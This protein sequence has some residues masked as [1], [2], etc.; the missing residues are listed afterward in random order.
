MEEL[1]VVRF[2]G[3]LHDQLK[4]SADADKAL[5][6]A[7]RSAVVFLQAGAGCVVR[8]TPAADTVRIC[9]S[10]PENTPWDI[11]DLLPCVEALPQRRPSSSELRLV[12]LR[13]RGN[14]WATIVFSSLSA[15]NYRSS[16]SVVDRIVDTIASALDALDDARVARLRRRIILKTIG[17][18]R[19]KD[20]FY[21][22]LDTIRSLTHYDHSSALCL[23]ETDGT[24]ILVAEQIA[25]A[26]I[27]SDR[28]GLRI[29]IPSGVR[30]AVESET[31][32]GIV[33]SR[34]EWR[35]RYNSPAPALGS[36]LEFRTSD[37]PQGDLPPEQSILCVAITSRRSL[38]G[39]IKIA[40]QELDSLGPYEASL[41]A[42][43]LPDVALAV[44]YGEATDALKARL[45]AAERKHAMAE[46]ARG[47][48][49]D[50]NNALG[51]MKPL[52]EQIQHDLQTGVLDTSVLE[53]DLVAISRA[54][55]VCQR[56]F[57]GMLSFAR[58][59]SLARR[60]GAL[61]EAIEAA[62]AI[63]G[64]AL[65]RQA[66][67]VRAD[68]Q[69]GLPAVS[70]P[71]GELE[72]LCLNLFTNA[73]DA[74]PNGGVLTVCAKA[75]GEHVEFTVSDTGEGIDEETRKR[76]GEPFF[77]TKPQGTG[78]GLSICRAIIWDAG[79]RLEISGALG[80]GTSVLVKLPVHVRSSETNHGQ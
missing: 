51:T 58:R 36:L 9:Y 34:D 4:R 70:A 33:R 37:S 47:V 77:T 65:A 41:L 54:L 40:G 44:D 28:I 79:G 6:F 17:G 27:P 30:L 75:V 53:A 42:E 56:L 43:L 1:E 68:V 3:A 73:R 72:Q 2:L 74:M 23:I 80:K 61:D 19:P 48:A 24:A 78:L 31:I 64:D 29:P 21:H 52:V 16:V 15:S 55:S 38:L 66:V 11:A 22:I 59:Q 14:P 46:L 69:R 32:S 26:K 20:L 10:H 71:V 45:L 76:L 57:S 13:R 63:V 49:H 50:V 5:R 12:S 60:F 35:D 67:R 39:F 8:H 18:P 62:L 7:I 25:C